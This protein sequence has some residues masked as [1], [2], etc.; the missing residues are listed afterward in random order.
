M[1]VG[2][3]QTEKT[4]RTNTHRQIQIEK[5]TQTGKYTSAKVSREVTSRKIQIEQRNLG[6]T[7]RET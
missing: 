1:Q 3:F 2:K 6:N 5:Q 4:A 7:K